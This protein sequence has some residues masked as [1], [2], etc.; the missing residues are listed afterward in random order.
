MTAV[1]LATFAAV[2]N[3]VWLTTAVTTAGLALAG[4]TLRLDAEAR[5]SAQRLLTQE[6]MA[7]AAEAE[8]AA[9]ADGPV[10]PG[11]STTCWRTASRPSSCTWRR[12]GC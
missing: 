6:R 10:S 12:P 9:L 7:R 5:G 11:R 4:Y 2:N 1:S 3:D 8:S